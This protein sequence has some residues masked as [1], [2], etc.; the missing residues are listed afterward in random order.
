[1][2]DDNPEE[3]ELPS[4]VTLENYNA[5]QEIVKTIEKVLRCAALNRDHYH[6]ILQLVDRIFQQEILQEES[7]RLQTLGNLV[8]EKILEG[9]DVIRARDFKA[10]NIDNLPLDKL[11]DNLVYKVLR[12]L[13]M[14]DAFNKRPSDSFKSGDPVLLG[15]TDQKPDLLARLFSAFFGNLKNN[16]IPLDP[17][18]LTLAF[19]TKPSYE[20]KEE[21]REFLRKHK[22]FRNSFFTQTTK[23]QPF[24]ALASLKV[25]NP[26]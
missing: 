26:Q 23:P 10:Y 13:Y 21:M 5:A 24:E 1:V 7:V 6:A 4:W 8:T 18:P 22:T 14:T 2:G 25:L 15:Y 16:N 17:E 11:I 20:S 3:P 12:T 9:T 19:Y